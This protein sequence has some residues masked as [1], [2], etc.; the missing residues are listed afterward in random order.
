HA[1]KLVNPNT[2]T[3]AITSTDLKTPG[4]IQVFVENF[5]RGASCAA[6]AALRF[7]VASSP[8]VKPTP[9]SLGFGQQLAGTT[10]ASKSVALKNTSSST[11]NINSI[12]ATGDFT[13]TGPSACGS[14]L[15]VGAS[16][17]VS[18]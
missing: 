8:I 9:L 10:S 14:T 6:F 1:S 5:P 7:N 18:L 13:I 12:S 2:L 3:V 15:A 17:T 16:C 11:V 4:G